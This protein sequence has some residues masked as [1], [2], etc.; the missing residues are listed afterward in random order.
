MQSTFH[1]IS[2]ALAVSPLVGFLYG[3]LLY[4]GPPFLVV[5]IWRKFRLKPSGRMINY[6]F[7]WLLMGVLA[8]L[9]SWLSALWW[10]VFWFWLAVALVDALLVL[11]VKPLTVERSLPMRFA[12]GVEAEVSLTIRNH[13]RQNL[14]LLVYDGLPETGVSEGMPWRGGLMA[15]SF[16][17]LSY[18]L[19]MKQRGDAELEPAHI[20]YESLFRFWTRQVRAGEH[21]ET[22]VYPNYE[23]VVR[24]ALLTMESRVEQMGIR[25]KNRA[26]LSK[27]FHQLR[28]Y[29]IGD[30]LSQVD[31]KATS[32][33]RQIISRDYQE[34]RDQ[35]LILAVDCGRRMRT[36]DGAISQFDHCLNAVLLL[37]Y[38][39]LRQGDQV[40]VLSYGGNDRWLPPQKGMHAMTTILNHLYDYETSSSPS[41]YAEAAERILVHQR[42]RALVVFLSNV[43]GEDGDDLVEPL[44]RLT[45]KHVVMLGNLREKDVVDRLNEPVNTL[46]EAAMVGAAHLYLKERSQVLEGLRSHGIH[47]VDTTAQQFPIELANHYRIARERV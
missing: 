43:R 23:P 37:A 41:D 12:L 20:Q 13:S 24:F 34:Q 39:A 5:V 25:M 27:E 4:L 36:M 38:V 44:R 46:D 18:P 32:K 14:R 11:L 26:G 3:L 30:M 17:T 16:V 21:Q 35:T 8:S 19:I 15:R 10:G 28:E 33:K 1:L 9:F 22:K 47:T 7:V 29:Q 42:R 45:S 6:A 2:T 40:G 31:W